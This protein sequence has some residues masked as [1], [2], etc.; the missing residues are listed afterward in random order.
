MPTPTM[1]ATMIAAAS[2]APAPI[3]RLRD[4]E[5]F[6]ADRST[7]LGAMGCFHFKDAR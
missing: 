5:F 3:L 1:M 7:V 4:E 6:D 2:K